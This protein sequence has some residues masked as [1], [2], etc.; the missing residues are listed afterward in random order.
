MMA[1]SPP[2]GVGY[3]DSQAAPSGAIHCRSTWSTVGGTLY[4]HRDGTTAALAVRL[5]PD[6]GTTPTAASDNPATAPTTAV[7]LVLLNPALVRRM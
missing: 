4:V 6:T 2:L 7:R 1:R 3:E 5:E